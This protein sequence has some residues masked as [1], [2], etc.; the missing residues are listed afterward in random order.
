MSF[1][2]GNVSHSARFRLRLGI[3]IFSVFAFMI[4]AAPQ[5][6]AA[7]RKNVSENAGQRCNTPPRGSG[8]IV[9]IFQG[10]GESA[11]VSSDYPE[12]ISRY[13]CFGSIEECKGWLYTMQSLY[14][15]GL[16]RAAKCLKR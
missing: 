2:S 9:G 16:P 12:M 10:L 1:M 5:V 4:T 14:S 15:A 7:V 11:F 8:V 13:R 6:N 3:S